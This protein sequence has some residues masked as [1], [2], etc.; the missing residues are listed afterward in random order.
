MSASANKED[1]RLINDE[2][3]INPEDPPSKFSRKFSKESSNESEGNIDN[4]H[5]E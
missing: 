2:T 3:D 4:E 5:I 1:E